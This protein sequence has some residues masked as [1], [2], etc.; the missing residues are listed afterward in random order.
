MVFYFVK[1][2]ASLVQIL[3][4]TAVHP[5]LLASDEISITGS[6]FAI[7]FLEQF[8]L[9]YHYRPLIMWNVEIKRS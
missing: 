9:L 8:M 6:P 5:K 3:L 4:Q 1:V 2:N 7:L